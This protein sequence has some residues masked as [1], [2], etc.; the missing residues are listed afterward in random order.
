MT[1]V[2]SSEVVCREWKGEMLEVSVE[3]SNWSTAG[4][5]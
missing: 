1:T 2:K 4:L 5:T 3:R